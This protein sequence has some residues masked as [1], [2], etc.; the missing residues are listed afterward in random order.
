MLLG[1]CNALCSVYST[2]FPIRKPDADHCGKVAVSR[3]HGEICD[4]LIHA[5]ADPF[6]TDFKNRYFE[7]SRFY[8]IYFTNKR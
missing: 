7:T 3:G 6:F 5:G 1:S 8:I 4:M 2:L